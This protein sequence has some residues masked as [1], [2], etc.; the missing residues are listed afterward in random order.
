[1]NVLALLALQAAPRSQM[2]GP[3][4]TLVSFAL[5]MYF[6]IIRPQK[7]IQ[8]QHRD[9]IEGVKKGDEVMSEGGLIGTVVHIAEDRVTLK[10]ADAR[11]VISKMKIA[12]VF[13][14]TTTES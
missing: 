5:I 12:R 11:V 4:I 6:L 10:S 13:T 1:M 7:R 9:L 3:A 8:S 14:A 2:I